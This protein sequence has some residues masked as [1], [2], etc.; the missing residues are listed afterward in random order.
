MS[1]C[2]DAE[3]YAT[4]ECCNNDIG[5]VQSLIKQDVG[6]WPRVCLV[7]LLKFLSCKLQKAARHW[8]QDF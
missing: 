7:P 6:A 3:K 2:K 8:L 4:A 5:G 1:F